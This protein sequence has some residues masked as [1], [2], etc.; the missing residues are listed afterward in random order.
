MLMPLFFFFLGYKYLSEVFQHSLETQEKVEKLL[1]K[2]IPGLGGWKHVA[3]KYKM[4]E[5]DI[6]SLEGNQEAGK[7][8]IEYLRANNTEL[9]VYE[10]CK[11]LKESN[12]RRLDIV[13]QLLGHLSAPMKQTTVH[14]SEF[15]G[16]I[17]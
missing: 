8:I 4:D 3:F 13:N 6:S 14:S 2:K 11:T 1:V 15:F 16:R 12:I 5:L 7:S 9:T 10:F 17:A